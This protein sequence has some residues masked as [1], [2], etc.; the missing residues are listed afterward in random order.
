MK[1]IDAV[2]LSNAIAFALQSNDPAP[3]PYILALRVNAK[4][5]ESVAA[6]YEESRNQ[7]M[8]Q[9]ESQPEELA[10]AGAELLSQE[11]NVDLQMVTP[12]QM[13]AMA[14]P[15]ILPMVGE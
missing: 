3:V 4:R 9:Y 7:L 12:A 14:P 15:S 6:S 8:S 10:R 2:K 11:I 5:L 13:P 1:L